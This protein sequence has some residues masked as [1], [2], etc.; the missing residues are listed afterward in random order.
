VEENTMKSVITR[1]FPSIAFARDGL[2][3]DDAVTPWRAKPL[4]R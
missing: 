1:H 2:E 3:D 4:P